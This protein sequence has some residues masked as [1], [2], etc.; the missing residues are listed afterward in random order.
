VVEALIEEGANVNVKDRWGQTPLQDAVNMN[1]GQV[2][3]LL[4]RHG[5]RGLHSSTFRLNMSRV[6][7]KKTP[8]TG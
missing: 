8:Y 3:D 1:H 6:R 7:H 4:Q 2:I 5:G